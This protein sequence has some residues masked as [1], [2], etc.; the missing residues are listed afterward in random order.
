MMLGNDPE[1][2]ERLTHRAEALGLVR[3]GSFSTNYALAWDEELGL[4]RID[5]EGVVTIINEEKS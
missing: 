2:T 3:G 4:V 5:T 1:K